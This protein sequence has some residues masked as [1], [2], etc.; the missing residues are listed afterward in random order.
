MKEKVLAADYGLGF[1]SVTF[2]PNSIIIVL[3][4]KSVSLQPIDI[5]ICR[6]L[7]RFEDSRYKSN[8]CTTNSGPI[9]IN[10]MTNDVGKLT[11]V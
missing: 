9:L 6:L 2:M 7:N 5:N 10:S 8:Y 1:K 11:L 3:D 4:F